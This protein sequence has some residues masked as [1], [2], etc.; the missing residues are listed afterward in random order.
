M[1]LTYLIAIILKGFAWVQLHLPALS[2]TLGAPPPTSLNHTVH[3]VLAKATEAPPVYVDNRTVNHIAHI[4]YEAPTVYVYVSNRSVNDT[5]LVL[6]EAPAAIE[7]LPWP[8]TDLL[9]LADLL[10]LLLSL[11]GALWYKHSYSTTE[12]Q[13]TVETQHTA[14]TDLEA[15][16]ATPL[17]CSECKD[18][19]QEVNDLTIKLDKTR[20]GLE[21]DVDELTIRLDAAEKKTE[22][23]QKKLAEPGWQRIDANVQMKRDLEAAEEVRNAVADELAE[24]HQRVAQAEKKLEQAQK[25]PNPSTRTQSDAKLQTDDESPALMRSIAASTSTASQTT[26]TE[27]D[28][29]TV[30]KAC[31][32]VEEARRMEACNALEKAE[33]VIAGLQKAKITAEGVAEQERAAV[34]GQKK[35]VEAE[36]RRTEDETKRAN[37]EQKRADD[38]L[39][40]ADGECK[41]ADTAHAKAGQEEGARKTAESDTAEA[42]RLKTVAEGELDGAQKLILAGSESV[43]KTEEAAGRCATLQKRADDLDLELVKTREASTRDAAAAQK[44]AD[45]QRNLLDKRI[46]ELERDVSTRLVD[47]EQQKVNAQEMHNTVVS[48]AE[49]LRKTVN[50]Y[51]TAFRA[52]KSAAKDVEKASNQAQKDIERLQQAHDKLKTLDSARNLELERR[53][54]ERDTALRERN[55]ANQ[56]LLN[57]NTA[58]VQLQDWVAAEGRARAADVAAADALMAFPPENGNDGFPAMDA[59]Q[60]GVVDNAT[61]SQHHGDMEHDQGGPDAMNGHAQ[62]LFDNDGLPAIGA[63]QDGMVDYAA[64][65]QHYG[66]ENRQ[67]GPYFHAQPLDGHDADNQFDHGGAQQGLGR[68]TN[69]MDFDE[70]VNNNVFPDNHQ[71]GLGFVNGQ[72][73]PKFGNDGAP[74]FDLDGGQQGFG[75]GQQGFGG[76]QQGV[77]DD[78]QGFG[79]EQGL[80]GD[81]EGFGGGQQGF[82]GHQG[83]DDVQQG[84]GGEH[85]LDG[86]A[87]HMDPNECIDPRLLMLEGPANG[88]PPVQNEQNGMLDDDEDAEGEDDDEEWEDVILR[89]EPERDEMVDNAAAPDDDAN[90]ANEAIDED[91]EDDEEDEDD[92]APA[93]V[94]QTAFDAAYDDMLPQE[95]ER[96]DNGE[97]ALPGLAV[98]DDQMVARLP[99][100]PPPEHF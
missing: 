54:S 92:Q 59:G 46:K 93:V 43:E 62:P 79:G 18:L 96:F 6:Y 28:S 67:V 86:G 27:Y 85:G 60:N 53:T 41:R 31:F 25:V 17:P 48:Q 83:L 2:R 7:R 15:E 61:P 58:Y 9:V 30:P 20:K 72:A 23:L 14:P 57:M 40:R 84:F 35:L 52:Q 11:R 1:Q 81:Q 16:P 100:G 34:E 68:G 55:L 82:G 37:H 5:A 76:G 69:D 98:V 91:D 3:T 33:G 26:Q 10:L 12:P 21:Q 47:W 39:K 19:K 75:G 78:Q 74:P 8:T 45:H 44:H 49:Q 71:E 89:P 77:D 24:L 94:D 50:Q 99:P 97:I 90:E 65:Q 64:P 51:E 56:G 95:Q 38:E 87:N 13:L 22:K 63:G 66:A 42:Q 80:D 36:K 70:L 29:S 4:L 73:Q 32:E 88:S